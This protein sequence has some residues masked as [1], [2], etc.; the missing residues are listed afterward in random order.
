LSS[1][2]AIWL[3]IV[4]IF[5]LLDCTQAQDLPVACGNSKV[6][7]RMRGQ[8]G[9]SFVWSVQGGSILKIHALGD[10]IDVGWDNLPDAHTLTCQEYVANGCAGSPVV[11]QV[12]VDVLSLNLSDSAYLCEGSTITLN[13][14][15]GFT[16]YQWNTGNNTASIQVKQPGSYGVEAFK[17][18]CH[19][20][21]S[22]KV[23]GLLSPVVNLGNDTI[24]KAPGRLLLDAQNPGAFYLWNNDSHNQTRWVEEGEGEVWVIVT[25]TENCSASDTI[26][27]I[28]YMTRDLRIPNVFTPNGDGV[29]DFWRIGGLQDYQETIIKI[30][31]S[32]GRLIFISEPGYP[33]P[34]NGEHKGKLLPMD[35]Y[36]YVIDLKNGEKPIRGSV[37]IIP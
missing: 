25:N 1:K 27:I 32:W 22:I 30:F 8:A 37:T 13:A 10:S 26:N 7:Y 6:R 15:D 16:K 36:Y 23:I 34:W 2:R 12:N 9:S 29:N 19:V 5:I 28:P 33:N 31:D 35:T 11:T 24:L 17:G 21:D 3:L 18:K 4:G 20:K 14:G